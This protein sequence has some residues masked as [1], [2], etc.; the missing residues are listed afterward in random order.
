MY[1]LL[2]VNLNKAGVKENW[3]QKQGKFHRTKVID[4][5]IAAI[6]ILFKSELFK[7]YK[8]AIMC[9]NFCW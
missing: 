8:V 6:E 7:E 3:F 9:S 5:S 1:K 2:Y 4:H